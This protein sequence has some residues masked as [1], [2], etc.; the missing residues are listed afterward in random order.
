MKKGALEIL[1]IIA[2]VAILCVLAA[3]AYFYFTNRTVDQMLAEDLSV[4]STSTEIVAKPPLTAFRRAQELLIS[5]PS[6]TLDRGENL[7]PGQIRLPDGRITNPEVEGVDVDG[8]PV[9]FR[10]R[11]HTLSEHDYIVFTPAETMDNRK[12]A[13]IRIRSNELFATGQIF[14]RNRNPK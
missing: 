13:K 6:Y 8:N 4:S 3:I 10:F 7:P 1:G 11:G 5:I 9:L 12:I 2:S 14:W